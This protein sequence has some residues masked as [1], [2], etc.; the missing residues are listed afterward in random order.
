MLFIDVQEKLLPKIHEHETL[1]SRCLVLQ[2]ACHILNIP[3]ITTEQYPQGLGKS[4]SFLPAQYEKTAFSCMKDRPIYDAIMN[5]PVDV[6]FVA[7]IE[8]H[9]CVLQTVRDLISN[10]KR[11]VVLQDAIGS[12]NPLDHSS[13]LQEM[14]ALNARI[15][16]VET[17]LF[18]LVEDAKHPDFK[19]ISQLIK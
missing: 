8:S 3:T 6:W 15:T 11:V 1:L 13:S 5:A 10:G 19:A 14:R 9:V 17:L 12:R 4:V 7:G 2:K 18:E 16:T